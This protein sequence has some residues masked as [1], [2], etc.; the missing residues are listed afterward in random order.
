MS[1]GEQACSVPMNC[2]SP[3]WTWFIHRT[4]F[5]L[6]IWGNSTTLE[7]R[8]LVFASDMVWKKGN[9]C[10]AGDGFRQTNG[11]P[12]SPS[13]AASSHSQW[14]GHVE[15]PSESEEEWGRS[16]E[17]LQAGW[18]SSGWGHRCNKCSFPPLRFQQDPLYKSFWVGHLR[19]KETV[20]LLVFA[21]FQASR[22]VQMSLHYFIVILHPLLP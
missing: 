1:V 12:A 4:P 21:N 9:I 17:L 5:D 20:F 11:P 10:K 18:P 8:V 16:T 7:N 3:L 15:L 2:P 22:K 19:Y 6:G 13:H 14:K